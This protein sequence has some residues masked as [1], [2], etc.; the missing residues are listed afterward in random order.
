MEGGGRKK[1][2]M[3]NIRAEI[4]GVHNIQDYCQHNDLDKVHDKHRVVR[5]T[6]KSRVTN[7]DTGKAFDMVDFEDHNFRVAYMEEEEFN[8]VSQYMPV[9]KTIYDW[10]KTKKT[11]RCINRV[12][13]Y[14]PN[15]PVFVDISIVKTNKKVQYRNGKTGPP[16]PA[17]TIQEAGVFKNTPSYEVELEFQIIGCFFSVRKEETEKCG[18]Q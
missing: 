11:F 6:K 9:K 18:I 15:Y 3:S 13:F 12:R 7:P 1:I 8:M 4:G 14:H 10:P 5:F 2:W 17:E 16:S